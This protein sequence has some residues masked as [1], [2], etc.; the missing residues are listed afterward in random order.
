[1]I[2]FLPK[3]TTPARSMPRLY[4][5]EAYDTA[6][7]PDSHWR[8]TAPP[9]PDCPALTSSARADI[10]I[11]GAGYAGLNAALELA[12]GFGRDV[13]VLEAGQPGWGASGRNGGFVCAG[14]SKLSDRAIRARVGAA[15]AQA[16]ADFQAASVAR[17]AH[18]LTRY[19]IDADKGP[20]GE[21]A[22]AHSPRAWTRMQAAPLDPGARLLPPDALREAGLYAP[23]FHGGVLEPLG[24]SIHPLKYALGL[25][26]AAHSAGVRTYG[27]S[28]VRDL[29]P[30]GD[31]WLLRTDHGTLRAGKVLI[32]TNGYT[33]ERLPPWLARRVLPVLSNILV[34]RPLSPAEQSA[35]GWTSRV[36]AYDT[37][38]LLHYFRLL[39]C[40]R[41]LFGARGGFSARP[42]ALKEF[43][44]TA[45]AEFEI[46]FPG[47]AA[48]RTERSWSGLVC[49]TGSLAPYAG[50]VPGADG[51]HAALGWHGNGVAA[52][53]EA[54]RRM[55]ALMAEGRQTLPALLRQPPP[56]IP[57]PRRAM[58]RAG[59]AVLRGL[60]GPVARIKQA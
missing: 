31:G 11:I 6:H 46:L 60:D 40:G 41:F 2:K 44:A 45:R 27:N 53:S 22:L 13:A 32:A 18:N 33:D 39:P 51:L 3:A 55:A 17:V 28:A 25:A 1:M 35:Q 38:R 24:F 8:A 7:W 10:A 52:A 21:L 26:Q 29:T 36:M 43:E 56:R 54:G 23:R 12:E 16:F 34:T 47:F 5:A 48:A 37:R 49:L 57:L 4:E 9:A 30:Q 42:S 19:G 58:L 15:G 59:M 50:S 20:E 14:S